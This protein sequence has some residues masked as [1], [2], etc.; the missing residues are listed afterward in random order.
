MARGGM[1]PLLARC[2]EDQRIPLEGMVYSAAR[3]GAPRAPGEARGGGTSR[4]VNDSPSSGSHPSS[5]TPPVAD[6]AGRGGEPSDWL[7]ADIARRVTDA[8]GP[9]AVAAVWD[10]VHGTAAGRHNGGGTLNFEPPTAR[11]A[12]RAREAGGGIAGSG[13]VPPCWLA[14]LSRLGITH[15]GCQDGLPCIADG[16]GRRGSALPQ[17]SARPQPAWSAAA[18]QHSAPL[19]A[20]SRERGFPL[21]PT[22]SDVTAYDGAGSA[23]RVLHRHD[24]GAE[25]GAWLA[26]DWASAPP[27]CNTAARG[28]RAAPARQQPDESGFD[29]AFTS[30]RRGLTEMDTILHRMRRL[31][32]TDAP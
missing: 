18:D 13:A 7:G 15:C 27:P 10:D 5:A 9:A 31:F 1:D 20:G 25:R 26:A 8:L 30:L 4:R 14:S 22:F 32:P 3:P 24:G 6:R 23:Q 16:S 12:P 2:L 21:E 17:A 11:D 19:A 28:V 29:E